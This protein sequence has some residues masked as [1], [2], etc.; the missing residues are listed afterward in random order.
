MSEIP[1]S[2]WLRVG[3]YW[4]ALTFVAVTP[5]LAG[6]FAGFIAP[7]LF[8]LTLVIHVIEA[9]HSLSLSTR[10]GANRRRWFWR[11]L[12]IG[13]FSIRRSSALSAAYGD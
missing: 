1:E 12:L 2:D 7:G 4:M 3:F 10:A 8:F 9:F 6:S 11:T 13:R 5:P